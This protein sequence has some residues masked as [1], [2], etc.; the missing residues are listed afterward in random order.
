MSAGVDKLW[1]VTRDQPAVDADT[2]AAAVEAAAAGDEPLDFRTRL[3]VRDSLRA[4][5]SHWGAPRFGHWLADGRQL[6]RIIGDSVASC[7]DHAFPSLQRRI[8]DATKPETVMRLLRDL[9]AEV[10]TPTRMLIGGSIALILRGYLARHTEDLDVVDEVPAELRVRH[11]LLNDLEHRY[12]LRLAHF[13]SHYLPTGWE[14]RVG[15][16]GAFGKLQVFAVDPYDVFVGKLFSSRTKDRDD[17]Q[18]VASQL[19]RDTLVRRVRDTT[20]AFRGEAKLREAAEKNWFVL[21]G[22]PLPG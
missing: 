2:L 22:E 3:L 15:S 20:A 9:S 1:S 21:F 4:L 16:V 11:D 19:D 7:D 18:A 17:L 6:L 10:T 5:E 12:G 8:V 14:Q 13:Q